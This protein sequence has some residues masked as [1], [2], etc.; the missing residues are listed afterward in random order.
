MRNI[1]CPYCN[2]ELDIDTTDINNPGENYEEECEHCGKMFHVMVEY[3]A[4]YKS[5]QVPCL[6]GDDHKWKGGIMGGYPTARTKY[7]AYCGERRM[8]TPEEYE[9]EMKALAQEEE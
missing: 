5:Y 6:N 4:T 2:K 7:C 3:S 8:P 1:T 9:I